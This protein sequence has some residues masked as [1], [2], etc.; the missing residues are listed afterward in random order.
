MPYGIC[1]EFYLVNYSVVEWSGSV[2]ESKD[3]LYAVLRGSVFLYCTVR[4]KGKE[5]KKKAAGG[6]GKGG[7]SRAKQKRT[8]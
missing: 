7:N 1:D 2:I 4:R 6:G 3:W 5:N 8:Q